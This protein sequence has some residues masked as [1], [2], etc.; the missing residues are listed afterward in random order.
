VVAPRARAWVRPTCAS[1]AA[2]CQRGDIAAAD[3][4]LLEARTISF[5]SADLNAAE[6]ELSA[7][8]AKRLQNAP[9]W[10]APTSCRAS[11]TRRQNFRRPSATATIDGWV[12]LEF[13]VLRDG[14]TGDIVVTNSN[15]RK[16]FDSAAIN[17]VAQWRY[18]PV[19]RDGKAVEQRA[20]VR[21]RF[22]DE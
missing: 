22:T 12:E 8:R 9:A 15:P 10:S 14:T 21:I 6:S 13:T 3:S 7:A 20:A 5:V 11:T 1:C 19:M 4:W 16:T 18:E 17:A 2:H